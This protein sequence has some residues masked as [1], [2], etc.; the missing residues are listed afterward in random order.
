MNFV[1]QINCENPTERGL[2]FI[3]D[4]NNVLYFKNRENGEI[5]FPEIVSPSE[6]GIE[7]SEPLFLGLV[8]GKNC[9]AAE[10]IS[11]T[12]CIGD[13][14][15][16]AE[17]NFANTREIYLS[18][19]DELFALTGRALHL[20]NWNKSWKFCPA[21]GESL[22]DSKKERVK[23]CVKCK[24][25]YYPVL[26]PAIIIAITKKDKLLLAHNNMYPNPNRYSVIAGFVESGESLEDTI[27]REVME[28]VSIRVK[29]IKYFG[30]QSWPFPNSLMVGFTAEYESGEINVDG[31]EI[32]HADWF[33]PD[34]FPEIPPYGS[35]SRRLI[36]DFLK[37]NS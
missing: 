3:F 25:P 11:D 23:I 26:S 34:N 8:D 7:T 12:A 6:I 29:N 30:S 13:C 33:S 31:T 15:G 14:C 17:R 5:F 36:D 2:W 32:G 18:I 21:C 16:A 28:E 10:V 24:T 19:G 20:K 37:N 35:I 22:E 27:R 1:T 4:K 9:W